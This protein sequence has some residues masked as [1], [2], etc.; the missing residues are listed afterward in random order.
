M[1]D[2]LEKINFKAHD[3]YTKETYKVKSIEWNCFGEINCITV[4]IN[5]AYCKSYVKNH[6]CEEHRIEA[7]EITGVDIDE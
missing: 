7:L 3:K 5:D 4:F 1:I 2:K 6:N